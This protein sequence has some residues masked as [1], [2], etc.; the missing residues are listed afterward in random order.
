MGSCHAPHA[1]FTRRVA[2][3]SRLSLVALSVVSAGCASARGPAAKLSELGTR[4]SDAGEANF[5][6]ARE[7]M[8]RYTEG[9]VL[10]AAVGRPIA[11]A[12]TIARFDTISHAFALRSAVFGRLSDAYG[13]FG[14]LAA[15]DA[16]GEFGKS[17]NSLSGAVQAWGVAIS[18]PM[19]AGLQLVSEEM[20]KGRQNQ[21]L[22]TGSHLLR[23]QLE[24]ISAL[25]R[26]EQT[27]SE[28]NRTNVVQGNA[29]TAVTLWELG[30]GRADGIF[31]PHAS[32]LGLAFD[33]LQYQRWATEWQQGRRASELRPPVR[34]NGRATAPP[35][36]VTPADSAL[37]RAVRSI[38]ARRAIRQG[39]LEAENYAQMISAVDRLIAAH[40]RF[41]AGQSFALSDLA[42]SIAR[43][44]TL[45]DEYEK[46]SGS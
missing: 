46:A 7:G 21:K 9:L 42:G 19:G 39:E 31:R 38:V 22:R 35:R 25:L 8:D 11:D 30:L 16:A 29:L 4:V 27:I 33:S 28:N 2:A 12:A 5:A 17:I 36:T 1:R 15:Y 3:L 45:L 18:A 37:H 44:Q 10:M 13:S 14:D 40:R 6:Q 26:A 32:T 41:E 23:A 34:G 43:L 20:M 24:V